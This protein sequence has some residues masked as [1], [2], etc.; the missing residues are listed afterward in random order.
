MYLIHVPF[1]AADWSLEWPFQNTP[2]HKIW[3]E[4]EKLVDIK[5]TKSIGV[6]NMGVA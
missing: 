3:A 1:P 5:L 6:S 4:M 2:M